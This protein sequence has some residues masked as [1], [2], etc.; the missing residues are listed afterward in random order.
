MILDLHDALSSSL[1][2]TDS[3]LLAY[4]IPEDVLGQ[5]WYSW[6]SLAGVLNALGEEHVL[7][8]GRKLNLGNP[9]VYTL[10]DFYVILS[11]YEHPD[12]VEVCFSA[13]HAI[14]RLLAS[15]P[16]RFGHFVSES[17]ESDRTL[18]RS[19]GFLNRP[20]PNFTTF[21]RNTR[22]TFMGLYAQTE[23]SDILWNRLCYYGTCVYLALVRYKLERLSP[24]ES[25]SVQSHITYLLTYLIKELPHEQERLHL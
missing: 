16:Y 2:K 1:G 7:S 6:F 13:D 23:Q 4:G 15:Q 8:C 17:T 21:Y 20:T 3:L 12:I 14:P 10:R 18:F 25:S 9:D 22:L 24:Q 11:R 5:S 19:V